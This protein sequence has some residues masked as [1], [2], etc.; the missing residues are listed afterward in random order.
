MNSPYRFFRALAG[1]G[2]S[3]ALFTACSGNGATEEPSES[4][5]SPLPTQTTIAAALGSTIKLRSG[6]GTDKPDPN[7]GPSEIEVAATKVADPVK[8][9]DDPLASPAPGNRLIAVEFTFT[10]RGVNPFKTAV[11][12]ATVVDAQGKSYKD[13][14]A[15]H[16]SV[17]PLVST[18]NVP[19][20]GT[21][22]GYIPFEVPQG[23]TITKVRWAMD[24]G[25]GQTGEWNL[26]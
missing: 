11:D 16:L 13:K 4:A 20:G 10:D 6:I 3:V 18:V 12:A 24:L 22:T 5:L 15:L 8:G 1:F 7:L 26:S 14:V 19:A 2:L 9:E 25:A 17:N 21:Q 23:A